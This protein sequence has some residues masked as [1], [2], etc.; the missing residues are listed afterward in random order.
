[1]SFVGKW[2]RMEIIRLNEIRQAQTAKYHIFTCVESG[3]EII[4]MMQW[5]MSVKRIQSG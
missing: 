3:P 1:M 4:K 2:V 5:D